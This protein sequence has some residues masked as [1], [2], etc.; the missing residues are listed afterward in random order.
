MGKLISTLL[1]GLILP[2]PV[3]AVSSAETG[4]SGPS[5]DMMGP[6]LAVL[7]V[8]CAALVLCAGLLTAVAV[9]KKQLAGTKA[10][11]LVVLYIAAILCL[12]CTVYCYGQFRGASQPAETT[13]ATTLPLET[14]AQVTTE[15]ATGATT[16]ATTVPE[17]EA[18]PTISPAFTANSDPGNWGIRW[19]TIQGG[20]VVTDYLR[21]EAIAFGSPEEYTHLE[22]II[23]FRGDNYRTGATYGTADVQTGT[24]T[25]IWGRDISHHNGWSG[26]GWTGQ[27]LI[28]RWDSDTRAVMNLYPDKQAK[29]DLVEVIYAT[30]DGHIYFY[31]LDDGSYTR[32]PIFLGMNFK[33]AGAL[34]PRGI[35]MMYVGSGD[36][37]NGKSPRM[38]IISLIDGSVLYEKSG[39]DAFSWREWAAF[40]S[41]P[42]VDAE[43]DT[44]IWPGESGIL[45][46]IKLNTAYDQAAG[47]LSI[48]PEEAAKAR[49]TTNRTSGSAYWVGYEPSC[50]IVDHY[51]YTSENG[52][53][54]FCI[55]LN[56]MELVWSQD[57]R[58]D[59]NSTPVFQW[60][61]D[62]KGYLYTAPSL[63]WTQDANAQ[64]Y[65]CIYKLDAATGEIVWEK[66]Y[67]CHT[68]D[69]VSGGVQST[70]LL[71]KAGTEL[72]GMILYTIA[73]TPNLDD[74]ALVA[75][76]TQTGDVVWEM[77]MTNY[78][79]SSPVAFYTESGEA[80]VAVGDSA[81]NM[82][83]LDG[84]TGEVLQTLPMGAN[85]EASPAV[86]EDTLVVGTRG[87]RVLALKLE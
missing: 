26:S 19:E 38:Y 35:P 64:G 18:Q 62:G 44:L 69:G 2:G 25:Q 50:V 79:W 17:T 30:L 12:V 29:E 37:V 86:F 71:G 63:H 5:R 73:R 65:I 8:I 78:T 16:E 84:G 68:V 77:Y 9:K 24:L 6:A 22:G 48:A 45:Y 11:L 60:E 1:T 52:G 75:F 54:F 83:L 74:G 56:T 49:Y 27:P 66:R 36:Y 53:L 58:D 42:L 15:A 32:D 10:V 80:Y 59:S 20:A 70:P 7:C 28:V 47:T 57:T 13:E 3:L 76:D 41:S 43:A 51:L 31:D 87:M 81:G 33:G 21:Q 4:V 40:D 85:V 46:T 14:T 61:A 55:D 39:S 82:F 72:E 34:D 23:T 67:D